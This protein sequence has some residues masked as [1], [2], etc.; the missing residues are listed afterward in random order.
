[1][2]A[3]RVPGRLLL[4]LYSFEKSQLLGIKEVLNDVL[5][6]WKIIRLCCLRWA[7]VKAGLGCIRFQILCSSISRIGYLPYYSD[8][9][10]IIWLS[11]LDGSRLGGIVLLWSREL[12]CLFN[13]LKLIHCRYMSLLH[14]SLQLILK[15]VRKAICP[16]VISH[17]FP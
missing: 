5:S 13:A 16:I 10:F 14:A 11:S 12:D 9:Y 1:M 2:L 4:D 8:I 6:C 15:K 17:I 7:M 3:L